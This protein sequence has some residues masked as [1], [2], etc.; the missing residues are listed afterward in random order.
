MSEIRMVTYAVA[1]ERRRQF[2]RE[3]A[4]S[5]A[6]SVVAEIAAMLRAAEA[7]GGKERHPARISGLE[8][9]QARIEESL[10]DSPVA[11]LASASRLLEAT[12]HLL[13]EVRQTAAAYKSMEAVRTVAN[14]QADLVASWRRTMEQDLATA[15]TALKSVADDLLALQQSLTAGAVM[16]ASELQ[17][18]L[19]DAAATAD[20]V[21][22]DEECRK[23]T[24][25]S[26]V[27][28]LEGNGFVVTAVDRVVDA[29]GDRVFIDALKPSGPTARFIVEQSGNM[30]WQ[31]ERY[32]GAA[33]KKDVGKLLP[34]LEKIYGIK[35]SD[36]RVIWENPDR[37]SRD[38]RPV[39]DDVGKG[40]YVHD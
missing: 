14:Q 24:V 35:L 2:E 23:E 29:S 30:A 22:V 26:V 5:R 11:A 39:T 15:P 8:D 13:A 3:R 36:S 40:G 32:E 20:Q 28:S 37:L 12:T 10:Q 1:E 4:R 6:A 17:Q 16:P 34:M 7:E 21:A 19:C 25:R 38:A 33:C 27:E 9:E 31:L 18:R